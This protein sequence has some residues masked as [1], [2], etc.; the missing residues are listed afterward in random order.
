VLSYPNL[1]VHSFVRDDAQFLESNGAPV[2]ARVPLQPTSYLVNRG[3]RVRV[4]IGGADP[5]HFLPLSLDNG[6]QHYQL[7]VHTGPDFASNVFLPSPTR[8]GADDG[9]MI[10]TGPASEESRV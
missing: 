6:A 10:V 2:E 5:A 1:P 9:R 8:D 3:Q 4:A 7:R